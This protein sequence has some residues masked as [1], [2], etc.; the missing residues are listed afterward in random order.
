MVS[1]WWARL[2]RWAWSLRASERT[3]VVGVL[4]DERPEDGSDGEKFYT[5]LAKHSD[6]AMARA[7]ALDEGAMDFEVL[8]MPDDDY[9][10]LAKMY[11]RIVS[12][13]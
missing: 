5:V 7:F 11:C 10:A 4:P 1:K 12:V 3:F 8:G 13:A 6:V 9:V 2:R